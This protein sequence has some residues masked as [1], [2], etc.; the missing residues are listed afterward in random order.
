M[1]RPKQT[2][3]FIFTSVTRD[4]LRAKNQTHIRLMTHKFLSRWMASRC[5]AMQLPIVLGGARRSARA[6][7]RK[8]AQ[9]IGS[10]LDRHESE[11]VVPF[12]GNC[13]GARGATRPTFV[14]FCLLLSSFLPC[15][16]AAEPSCPSC[17]VSDA[18]EA[19]Y[20]KALFLTPAQKKSAES[21]HVA[22]G[23]P[24]RGTTGAPP[25]VAGAPP[26]TSEHLLHQKD[27]L[28]WYD[29][30]RRVPL[31]VAYKITKNNIRRERDRVECF[32]PDPRLPTNSVGFCTDYLEK[33]F[34]QGH[35][36][37]NA[38]FKASEAMMIN[39][40]GTKG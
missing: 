30:D 13:H 32:R 14:Y 35:L 34:D 33:V 6:A 27:Y 23:L 15:C 7:N 16:T 24:R 17:E 36:A 3:Q 18:R 12:P 40:Y 5:E 8:E 22:Y 4:V 20:N 28:T 31:W 21:K 37:P 26:D 1:F 19:Q 25:V 38:D 10:S 39:T 29:D 11:I 9:A 2:A